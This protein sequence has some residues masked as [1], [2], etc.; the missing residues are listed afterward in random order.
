MEWIIFAFIIL[1]FFLSLT[2]STSS[3]YVYR[4]IVANDHTGWHT[5]SVRL[6]YTKERCAA[7]NSTSWHTTLTTNIHTPG[8]IE[9]CNP[10]KRATV[11]LRLRP[12]GS[13]V[14]LHLMLRLKIRS[15]ANHD[16]CSDTNCR[17]SIANSISKHITCDVIAACAQGV[18]FSAYL[19]SG[20]NLSKTNSHYMYR[21]FNIQQSYVLPTQCIYVFCVDLI[22]NSDYFP[23]QH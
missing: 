6:L 12:G 10:R 11:D 22:T 3:L 7:E 5:H 20:F 23:I 14:R 16:V 18:R 15:W 19:V 1:S 8:G 9:T 21:Q 13:R 2:S 17:S 4:V